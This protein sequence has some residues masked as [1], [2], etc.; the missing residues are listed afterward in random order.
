MLAPSRRL[1][2]MC[3]AWRRSRRRPQ[4]E[5]GSSWSQSPL[6]GDVTAS[7]CALSMV[8][9]K[10]FDS[11]S[12]SDATI[13]LSHTDCLYGAVPDGHGRLQT[14]DQMSLVETTVVSLVPAAI[15]RSRSCCWSVSVPAADAKK[16]E[17]ASEVTRRTPNLPSLTGRLAL[18][19][20]R[21]V[22]SKLAIAQIPFL[23]M[24]SIS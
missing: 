11:E 16:A 6:C 3:T 13:V 15:L 4:L 18:S 22:R 7:S 1:T 23:N 9:L 17:G 5:S 10:L 21:S 19:H 8:S 14:E 12:R 2:A 24:L 20:W